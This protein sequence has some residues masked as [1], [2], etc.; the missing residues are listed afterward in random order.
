[1]RDSLHRR[2]VGVD[3]RPPI[4]GRSAVMYAIGPFGSAR[5]RHSYTQ[6]SP[7][8]VDR[9]RQSDACADGECSEAQ[10]YE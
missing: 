4:E 8:S 1:M 7:R 2:G 6:S 9:A 3:Y 10:M 5:V